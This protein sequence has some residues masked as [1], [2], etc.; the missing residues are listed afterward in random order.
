MEKDYFH[1]IVRTSVGLLLPI[2]ETVEVITC[3]RKDIC[4]IPGVVFPL[5]GVLNQRGRLLWIV[6]LGDLLGLSRKEQKRR[7][8]DQLTV[9]ILSSQTEA[10]IR[11]GVVVSKLQGIVSVAEDQIAPV[12]PQMRSAASLFFDGITTI[13]QKK[14]GLINVSQV[15]AH[16]QQT[17]LSN[18]SIVSL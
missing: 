8:Q 11:L 1:I 7:A 18:Y 10:Q 6:G 4:P 12:S 17:S 2:T 5:R 3:L 13:D 9:V 16:L 15:F 14:V